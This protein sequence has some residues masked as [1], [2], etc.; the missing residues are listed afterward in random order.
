MRQLKITKSITNRD[1]YSVEMYLREISGIPLISTDEEVRLCRLIR[2]GD[3]SALQDLIEANLRF[4]VSV[5]KQFQ[6]NSAFTLN[7]LINE[8]NIGLVRAAY[9]FDESRGFKFISYAVWW[10]RQAIL[11]AVMENGRMIRLPLNQ[12]GLMKKVNSNAAALSQALDREPTDE[13]LAEAMNLNTEIISHLRSIGQNHISGDCPV[14]RETETTLYDMTEDKDSPAPDREMMQASVKTDIAGR[15]SLLSF[16]EQEVIRLFFGLEGSPALSL[17]NI[18][19]KQ[20]ITRERVRQIKDKA[21]IK[22]KRQ[23]LIS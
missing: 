3:M 16:R 11:Q 2:N 22:L 10:I 18:A 5:A 17:D 6:P 7:D 21:L 15:L 14:G 20:G 19:A 23:V 1:S 12:L 9:K 4:V 8:G 13:E